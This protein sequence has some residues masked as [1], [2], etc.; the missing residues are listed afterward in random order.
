[1]LAEPEPCV[2][3]FDPS[4][5]LVRI[6]NFIFVSFTVS[7]SKS[8]SVVFPSLSV[9]VHTP[10]PHSF[11]SFACIYNYMSIILLITEYYR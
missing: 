9:A 8:Y 10:V 11:S 7:L 5:L 4:T 3:G 2:A 6:G 1:M